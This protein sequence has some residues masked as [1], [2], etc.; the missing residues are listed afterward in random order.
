MVDKILNSIDNYFCKYHYF[1][2]IKT[3]I[4][5][6][7]I[8]LF[9]QL[10]YLE[11]YSLFNNNLLGILESVISTQIN[12]NDFSTSGIEFKDGWNWKDSDKSTLFNSF[13]HVFLMLLLPLY[14]L[15][16]TIINCQT[17]KNV[18]KVVN[19]SKCFTQVKVLFRIIVEFLFVTIA[20]IKEALASKKDYAN[21]IPT[22]SVTKEQEL[23]KR[24]QVN[25]LRQKELESQLQDNTL[26]QKELENQILNLN[27]EES[28]NIDSIQT[29]D[30]PSRAT[31]EVNTEAW[32]IGIGT[33]VVFIII[34]IVGESVQ[35]TA[36][37][38]SNN[39]SSEMIS[40]SSKIELC[41][42]Y[43]SQE[44]G[45]PKSIMETGF[46]KENEGTLIEIFYIRDMDNSEWRYVCHV[47][48]D[49]MVWAAIDDSGQLGRWRFEDKK[50]LTF[51]REGDKII[52]SF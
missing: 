21:V 26:R 7:L 2:L 43:I 10:I 9:V 47:Y 16:F 11:L 1:H 42:N 37:R 20:F 49:E 35:R 34:L 13:S 41:K 19:L 23:N 18:F 40:R 15:L 36:P 45:R 6:G 39:I 24:L 27:I 8:G 31:R 3:L 46:I 17:S 14:Y 33:L 48:S 50:K 29:N 52:V 12:L 38:V 22:Y 30:D 51:S 4:T 28:D 5:F 32:L 44:F 25:I